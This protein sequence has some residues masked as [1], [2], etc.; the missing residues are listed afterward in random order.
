MDLSKYKLSEEQQKERLNICNTC[1]YKIEITNMC[2]KCLCYLPWKVELA[3][4]SCPEQKWT[5]IVI[6]NVVE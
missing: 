1:E 3:P 5:N 2:G 4:A 6:N